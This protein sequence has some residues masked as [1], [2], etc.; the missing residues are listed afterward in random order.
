[1]GEHRYF[2][3]GDYPRRTSLWQTV[4]A[5][6]GSIVNDDD[7]KVLV[8]GIQHGAHRALDHRLFVIGRNQHRDSRLELRYIAGAKRVAA[9]D[10]VVDGGRADDERSVRSS[11]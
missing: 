11:G 6:G 8:I 7:V 5:V 3:S 10:A 2:T 4:G 1:M 9:L